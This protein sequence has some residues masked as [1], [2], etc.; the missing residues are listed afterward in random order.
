MTQ[1]LPTIACEGQESGGGRESYLLRIYNF[2]TLLSHLSFTEVIT[3]ACIFMKV[4]TEKLGTLP[5]PKSDAL[6]PTAV[7][8][9]AFTYPILLHWSVFASN[10]IN[11]GDLSQRL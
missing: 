4:F 3:F 9:V 11:C 5:K 6:L 2:Q 1:F 7:G 10:R 8:L